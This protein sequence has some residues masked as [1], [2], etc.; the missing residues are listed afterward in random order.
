MATSDEVNHVFETAKTLLD[1]R[2][3]KYG[4]NW[5]QHG[6]K[7][8]TPEM[9]RKANS[10]RVK[11]EQGRISLTQLSEDVLDLICWSAFVYHLIEKE[12]RSQEEK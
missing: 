1:E 3:K 7:T 10:T 5:K 8:C 12:L 9:F 2:E 4:D 6:R 11:W